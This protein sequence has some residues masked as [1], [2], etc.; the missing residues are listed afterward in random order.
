MWHAT[1]FTSKY[2]YSIVE[3][4]SIKSL[5]YTSRLVY[6]VE[7]YGSSD[8]QAAQGCTETTWSNPKRRWR[9][10]RRDLLRRFEHYI[11]LPPPVVI[12]HSSST[13]S[14]YYHASRYIALGFAR[15]TTTTYFDCPTGHISTKSTIRKMALKLLKRCPKHIS[16]MIVWI[17][18][19]IAWDDDGT[20]LL[21][22]I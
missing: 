19:W 18:N 16:L 17:E 11:S 5:V 6:I 9:R 1:I 13:Y 4:L 14:V 22:W 12:L 7:K 2:M 15:F 20:R 8:F 21:K 3:L 10:R